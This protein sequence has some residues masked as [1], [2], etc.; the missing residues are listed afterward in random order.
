MTYKLVI[1]SI[2]SADIEGGIIM[3]YILQ[4]SLWTL[5][6]LIDSKTEFLAELLEHRGFLV[7]YF[8]G[9]KES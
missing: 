8:I 7:F 3:Q 1:E 2:Y 5:L 4:G 6:Q 9:S